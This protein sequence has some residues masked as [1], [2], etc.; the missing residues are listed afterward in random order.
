MED[1]PAVDTA[2]RQALIKSID[3]KLLAH[4]E[5]DIEREIGEITES[6]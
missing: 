5:D 3:E 4:V 2:V 1:C 6:R